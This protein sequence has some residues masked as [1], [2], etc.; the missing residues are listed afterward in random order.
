MDFKCSSN[1]N[2]LT[3]VTCALKRVS[4][5]L[6]NLT[7][8]GYII[9]G[10]NDIVVSFLSNQKVKQTYRPTIIRGSGNVCDFMKGGTN[11]LMSELFP[12]A[13]VTLSSVLRECPYKPGWIQ[14]TNYPVDGGSV[15]QLLQSGFYRFDLAVKSSKEEIFFETKLFCAVKK[16]F[17]KTLN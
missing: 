3:N 5:G 11:R 16:K 14:V 1:P 17:V 6:A 9:K 8:S 7:I 15:S 4:P 10:S 2:V 13:K 12:T